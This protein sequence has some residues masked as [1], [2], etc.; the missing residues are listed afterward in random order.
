MDQPI[1]E[2]PLRVAM[3]SGPRNISTA[4]MRAWENRADTAVWDEPLYAYYLKATGA[5]HPLASEIIDH[6]ETDWRRVVDACLGPVPGGRK[7]FFQKHMTH[8]VLDEMSLDWLAGLSHVFL[9][10]RPDQV[11]ASYAAARDRFTVQD[12]GILQQDRLF[13]RIR[14]LTGKPP[15]VIDCDDVLANPEGLLRALCAALSVAFDPAMLSWP[16]GR[17]Q[18]DGIWASHWYAN[19]ERSTGFSPRPEVDRKVPEALIAMAEHCWPFYERLH[20][21]R[22]RAETL[23]R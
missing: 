7:I 17:R 5:D 9:M 10:R 13:D 23:Q 8:H 20:G 16:S 2:K 12:I 22:L 14:V 6:Y 3:W 11:I 21:V 18:T 19:V 4:M 15:P 1:E